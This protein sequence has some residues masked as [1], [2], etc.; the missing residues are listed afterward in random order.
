[1]SEKEE[2]V[3]IYQNLDISIRRDGAVIVKALNNNTIIGELEF[4]VTI[5]NSKLVKTTTQCREFKEDIILDILNNEL[6]VEV[7]KLFKIECADSMIPNLSL[8]YTYHPRQGI[9]Y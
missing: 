1:M 4:D 5:K 2:D 8:S 9:L 7:V 6:L 3:Y